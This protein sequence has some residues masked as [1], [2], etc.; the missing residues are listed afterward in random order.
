[1]ARDALG[2]S[3][4][5]G[6]DAQGGAGERGFVRRWQCV[7]DGAGVLGR[8]RRALPARSARGARHGDLRAER[9]SQEWPC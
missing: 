7:A 3:R 6:V 5:E 1:M 8:A 9:G 4:L 2:A